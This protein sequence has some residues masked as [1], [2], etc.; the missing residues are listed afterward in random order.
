MPAF[1]Y[2]AVDAEGKAQ[3]G[4]VEADAVRQAR[5][6]LRSRGL[7]PIEV[8][9]IDAE[10]L[11]AASR[12]LSP[13]RRIPASELAVL[14]R[15]FAVLLEAGL[16]I[17]QALDALVEQGD[18]ATSSRVLASVRAEV[19]SGHSL[20][21]ALE[22]H[23]S[24]FPELYRGIVATGEQ[25]GQLPGL[26][27]KLA[28]YLERRQETRQ[29]AGLTLLYPAIV[30]GV[31]L[32]VVI[33]LLAYVVPQVVQ[34]FE[35]SRQTL[36]FLTRA[37]L[38]LSHLAADHAGL[39]LGLALAGM[40]AARFA[41]ARPATRARVHALALRLP[42]IGPLWRG[43][44]TARLAG[45]LAILL[46][47]GVPLVRSLATAGKVVSNVQLRAAVEDAI[48]LV[49]EGQSLHRA[50]ARTSGFPGIFLHMV[51]SGEASG[52][53]GHTLAQAARQQDAENDGRVRLLTGILEPATIVAMAV[54]VLLVVLAI[55][56]PIIEINQHIRP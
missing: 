29:A 38:W 45:T 42:I 41:Y 28:E 3:R 11:V 37:M 12:W 31:A 7:V 15:R 30:A 46:D 8:V 18:G 43:R 20:A 23:P 22:Q 33:G 19:R 10:A 39:F 50:L 14:T 26:M 56:L 47:S 9:P 44:D 34:V 24:S 51:A 40:I 35:Q 32:A 4:V 27:L 25:S 13:R 17:E 53:L 5:A 52:R 55:L 2:V 48:R 1:Q 54:V 16:S 49:Q 6:G 36:P 21:A